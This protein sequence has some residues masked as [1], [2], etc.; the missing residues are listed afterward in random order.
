[1][2]KSFCGFTQQIRAGYLS[3]ENPQTRAGDLS[4]ENPQTLRPKNRKSVAMAWPFILM[5]TC[6]VRK[7]PSYWFN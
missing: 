4:V 6:V 2:S 5:T 7:N 1:M 3:V